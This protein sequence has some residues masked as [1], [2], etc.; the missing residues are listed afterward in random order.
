MIL[1]LQKKLDEWS[2]KKLISSEEAVAIQAYEHEHSA[3]G[4]SWAIYGVV[5]I[6]ITAIAVGIISLIA[7]NWLEIPA[8]VKLIAY[9]LLQSSVGYAL[10][11]FSKYENVWREA[12]LTM[13]ALLFFAGIGLI[14]Q[15]YHLHSH[16][17]RGLL[18]WLALTFPL[19]QISR[20]RMMAHLWIL[21]SFYTFF[22]WIEGTDFRMRDQMW[23]WFMAYPA[24][25]VAAAFACER[26]RKVNDYFRLA[27]LTWGLGIILIGGTLVMSWLWLMLRSE[28]DKLD[29]P[30]S[31]VRI[32]E[33]ALALAILASFTRPKSTP[34]T[35]KVLTSLMLLVFGCF[36]FL[37]WEIRKASISQVT[38]QMIG[39]VG[40][41]SVWALTA[42]S[43]VAAGRRRLFD[44]ASFMIAVR[45][46]V[47]YFEVFGSL[48][49][50][51][52]GLIMSGIVILLISGLWYKYKQKFH[53]WIG[54]SI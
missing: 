41:I 2:S 42:A 21:V 16:P 43:F 35:Q 22:T 19:T 37:P 13:F 50:T 30:I 25:L 36:F 32:S 18:F 46:I 24:L 53:H 20:G 29:L 27:A 40:F 1:N 14:A 44:I 7:A 12:L 54:G 4:R 11:R 48:T 47:I 3:G 9:F 39:A 45:F 15:V 8:E 31:A 28:Y 33:V 49:T 6:G 34:K 10:F 26:M 52:A 17:W 23:G 51:G 38:T 5:G